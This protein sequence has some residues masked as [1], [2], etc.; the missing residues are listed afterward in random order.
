[1]PHTFR[2]P[3][4]AFA[5]CAAVVC[6]IALSL[7]TPG[8]ATAHEAKP[9]KL[10]LYSQNTALDLVDTGNPGTDHGD[11]F[12]RKL[13][14]S[15]TLGGPVIGTGYTQ[16]E[17]ISFDN[18]RDIRRVMLQAFLPKGNLFLVGTSDLPLGALPEPGWTN[19]YAIMG[20]TGRYAGAVGTMTAVLLADGKSFK[21]TLT[22]RQG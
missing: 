11:L 22:Y 16:G 19:T 2:T 18:N 17:V 13:T 9:K 6:A 5:A 14:L 3:R 7:T 1:M 8:V 12:H 20:G 15:R 21:N 4:R 10:V